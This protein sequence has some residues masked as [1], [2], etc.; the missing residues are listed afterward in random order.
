MRSR[1]LCK[2]ISIP[3]PLFWFCRSNELSLN[4]LSKVKPHLHPAFFLYVRLRIEPYMVTFNGR[5]HRMNVCWLYLF[6]VCTV[7]SYL[8]RVHCLAFLL[9]QSSWISSKPF[10]VMKQPLNKF[11]IKG[12]FDHT[13]LS[14]H[15]SQKFVVMDTQYYGFFLVWEC[16]ATWMNHFSV[17]TCEV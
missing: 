4:I 9:L 11:S 3:L 16:L 14:L 7:W 5:R 1:L 15:F 17:M 12:H 8:W 2:S 13:N 10:L 6:P